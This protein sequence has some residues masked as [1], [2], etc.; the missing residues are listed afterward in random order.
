MIRKL[1]DRWLRRRKP[2][3]PPE[4]PAHWPA[5]LARDVPFFRRLPPPQR[6]PLLRLIQRFIAEKLFWAAGEID[7]TER[8]K[9]IVAAY[10][11]LLVLELPEFGLYPRATEVIIHPGSFGDT[12]ET[13]GPDGT[14]YTVHDHRAGQAIYRGPVLLAWDSVERSRGWRMAGRNVIIHEFAHALDFMDGLVNGTPPLTSREQDGQWVRV[15]AAEFERLRAAASAG[16]PTFLDPYGAKNPAE[17]FAVAT[18]A[19]FEAAPALRQAHPEL[20]AQLAAFYRQDPAD[21]PP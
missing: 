17:F 14:V 1:I 16:R 19:F 12:I 15:F 8:M 20:Y 13:I 21:W 7:I 18:E 9:L 2:A 4:I 6:D 3:P 5:Q 10:A 11:C